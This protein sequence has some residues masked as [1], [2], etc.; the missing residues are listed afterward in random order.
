LVLA[1]EADVRSERFEDFTSF[2]P[3]EVEIVVAKLASLPRA[4][5]NSFSVS[6]AEGAEATRLATAVWTNAVEAAWVVFVP[7]VAVGTAGVP[8]KVGEASGA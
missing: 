8:V 5:A 6:R 7:A 1:V 2:S 3:R 4:V